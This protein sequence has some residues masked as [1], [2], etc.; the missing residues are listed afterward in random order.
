MKTS[1][2]FRVSKELVPMGT[3]NGYQH[4]W[5]EASGLVSDDKLSFN[6]FDRGNFQTI[7]GAVH[8]GDSILFARVGAND[9]SFNLRRE[10]VF[11]IRRT[12]TGNTLFA[13]VYEVHGNYSPVEEIATDAYSSIRKVSIVH[14]S[15]NYSVV[16]I[17][18]V[19][20]KVDYFSI[21]NNNSDASAKHVV[22]IGN[23]KL[24]W[25]GAYKLFNR[26]EK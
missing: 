24:E 3:N 5:K 21:A 26:T 20:G 19:N 9:P 14:D 16:K 2:A 12:N 10:P 8:A 17:E 4:L 13:N 15:M 23:E 22:E 6:W 25:T 18:H 7:S 11:I 1:F